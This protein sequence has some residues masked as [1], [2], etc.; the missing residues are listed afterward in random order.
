VLELIDQIINHYPGIKFHFVGQT[1]SPEDEEYL[2]SYLAKY[3]GRV[4]HSI[5]PMERMSEAYEKSHI[6][7][8][9][10]I[11][12]EGT[13]LSAIEAMATNNAVIATDIGGLPNLILNNFNGYLISPTLE[14]LEEKMRFLLDNRKEIEQ[15]AANAKK[16]VHH[17]EKEKWDIQWLKTISRFFKL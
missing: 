15:L 11:C 13:S 8:I 1:N 17:F 9:P 4:Y 6:V 16:I 5:L 3:P 7:L 10:T 12:S 14:D 2:Q